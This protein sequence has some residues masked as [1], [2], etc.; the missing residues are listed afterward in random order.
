MIALDATLVEL[1]SQR[2]QLEIQLLGM[3]LRMPE[4]DDARVRELRIEI[5]RADRQVT[6]LD[7]R[8]ERLDS[9]DV[10]DDV[11][12]M[13]LDS[14]RT[15]AHLDQIRSH[16]LDTLRSLV[17]PLRQQYELAERQRRLT[18]RMR[19]ATGKDHSYAAYID[20]AL[21]RAADIDEELAFVLDLLKQS[22]AVA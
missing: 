20:T 12:A 18:S 13:S 4:L 19:E 9:G 15:S 22:R 17:E 10:S 3:R 8:I 16:I 7:G 11:E 2:A 21:L 1:K 5:D 6:E 14:L